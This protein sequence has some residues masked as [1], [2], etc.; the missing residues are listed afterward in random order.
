MVEVAP[1]E[2]APDRPPSPGGFPFRMVAYGAFG[3]AVLALVPTI[4][5]AVYAP[6]D[7][8]PSC[9]KPN[10][11][12]ACP[13][14]YSGNTGRAAGFGVLTGVAAIGGAVLLYLDYRRAHAPMISA[15]PIQGGF[16][17]GLDL[18]F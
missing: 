4:A 8:M 3:L 12:T 9:D 18:E 17:T 1:A 14:V 6:K 16:M 7:N 10:P 15:G 11:K 2:K 13:E 5:F